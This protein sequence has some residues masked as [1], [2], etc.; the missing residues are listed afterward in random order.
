TDIGDINQ[1]CIWVGYVSSSF[2][3]KEELLSVFPL[4][5]RSKGS[6]ILKNFLK[7]VEK[8]EQ[9]LNVAD[10]THF[11][12][13]SAQEM[14]KDGH[15]ESDRYVGFLCNLKE[16]FAT[17]FIDFKNMKAAFDFL[18]DPFQLDLSR[19]LELAETLDF[20]RRTFEMELISVKAA[21]ES[22]SC[23]GRSGNPTEMWQEIFSHSDYSDLHRLGA[24]LLLM[25]ASTYLCEM[26]FS[27]MNLLKTKQRNRIV[28][29]KMEAQLRIAV[30]QS[31]EPDFTHLVIERQA[32]ISH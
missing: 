29:M 25:F 14:N 26:T 11:S 7:S 6:D 20:D 12:T 16:K 21:Q 13:L 30:C 1:L 2:E 32:Q 17:R 3:V 31:F 15:F 19:M 23:F 8:F 28:D 10:F 4:L 9:H 22:S 18:R 27:V 24:K 5:Q